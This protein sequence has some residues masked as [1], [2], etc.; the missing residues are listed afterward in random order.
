VATPERRE[1]R[2]ASKIKDVE[3]KDDDSKIN[4]VESMAFQLEL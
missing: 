1:Q 2:I 4:T 3:K